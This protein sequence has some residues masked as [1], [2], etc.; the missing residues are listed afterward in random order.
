[1]ERPPATF[2]GS[3]KANGCDLLDELTDRVKLQLAGE[4]LLA[5]LNRSRRNVNAAP[6]SC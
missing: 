4:P 5:G 6:V 2:G 3:I 1:M